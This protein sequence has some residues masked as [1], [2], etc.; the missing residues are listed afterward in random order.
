VSFANAGNEKLRLLVLLIAAVILEVAVLS[1]AMF[2]LL[3]ASAMWS[4]PAQ[5]LALVVPRFLVMLLLVAALGPFRNRLWFGVFLA[6]YAVLLLVRFKQAEA[7]VAWDSAIGASRAT[8]PYVA[9]IVGA[10][11]GFWLRHRG[12][13]A[14]NAMSE[15]SSSQA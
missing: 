4:P 8:L 13:D 7:F 1:G 15:K 14:R 3:G 11:L 6:L 9:G 2:S 10:I 12:A 5:L